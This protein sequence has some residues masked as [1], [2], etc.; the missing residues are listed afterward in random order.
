MTKWRILPR[1]D[2][3]D[4]QASR[5]SARISAH[6]EPTKSRPLRA[7][8]GE[9]A[10]ERAS[11]LGHSLCVPRFRRAG[12]VG[13]GMTAL[14]CEYV[15][16]T[17]LSPRSQGKSFINRL[18]RKWAFVARRRRK[19]IFGLSSRDVPWKDTRGSFEA[20]VDG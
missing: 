1:F 2:L 3:Y 20:H 7:F 4:R 18:R 9:G 5:S 6:T 8:V 10:P 11:D 17:F 15:V 19:A 12:A 13:C 16:N 14:V